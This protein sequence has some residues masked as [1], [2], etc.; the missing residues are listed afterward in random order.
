MSR[1]SLAPLVDAIARASFIR[2]GSSLLDRRR[3]APQ[4]ARASVVVL[5][6][7]LAL[8]LPTQALAQTTQIVEYYHTDA[9]A[10]RH[11]H[12]YSRAA[13]GD[14][15][16]GH[17]VAESKPEGRMAEELAIRVG[18]V[19][20]VTNQQGEVIRRHDFLPFGEELQPT[21]PPPDKPLFTGKERDAETGLDYFGARYHRAGVGRFTTVD[22][23]MTLDEN[24]VDP[25]RWNRY[26]YARTNPLRWADPDG[27]QI[28][29]AAPLKDLERNAEI[30]LE[31]AV[32]TSVLQGP[33]AARIVDAVLANVLPKNVDEFVANGN[34]ALL[35]VVVPL[36][37]P[38]A[39]LGR[40]GEAAVRAAEG[41][42]GA[43]TK[44]VINGRAR[45]P[46]GLVPGELL[47]EV[48]NVGRQSFTRQL[49]DYA[50][51]T[52]ASDLRFDLWTREN[53]KLSGPLTEAIRSGAIN[54]RVIPR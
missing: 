19:R 12:E 11:A 54:L 38:A 50:D 44:I 37:L 39:E 49:R 1:R 28:R 53:T 46:D 8:M 42:I 3:T 45:I 48:K 27:R 43:K 20:A 51:F 4:L 10:L 22:P 15:E 24:L 31:V 52:R 40:V 29:Q 21:V 26:A 5:L 25:Q 34:A 13:Q 6:G 17:T 35:G 36:E 32:T 2:S 7:M 23:A 41:T 33:I 30:R 9:L 18:T 47:T 14:P 16:R